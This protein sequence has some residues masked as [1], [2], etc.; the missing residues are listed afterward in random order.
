MAKLVRQESQAFA[1]ELGVGGAL[2]DVAGL[3][4][5]TGEE[6][7]HRVMQV[8]NASEINARNA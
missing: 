7:C 3:S 6:D 4:A 5:M 1:L 2:V 8:R